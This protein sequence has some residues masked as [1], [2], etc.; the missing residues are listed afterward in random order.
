MANEIQTPYQTGATVYSQ[1]FNANS[2]SMIWNGT[3]FEAYSSNSGN[4][5]TYAIN[6]TE[7]GT[8]SKMYVGSFPQ[9]LGPGVYNIR[10]KA[11]LAAFYAESDPDVSVGAINWAGSGGPVRALSDIPTSGTSNQEYPVKIAKGVMTR[12]NIYLKSASDHITPL[13]SGVVSGQIKRDADASWSALQSGAFTEQ[14][15]GFYTTVLT[16]GDLN[17]NA[18]SLLFTANSVSGGASDPCPFSLV[19]QR[20]SGSP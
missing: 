12:F 13:T 15:Y 3:A 1:V 5:S 18:I 14:G 19:T 4:L 8:A 17:G 20:V 10:A 9:I 11:R 2:G 16:S 6:L 7:L